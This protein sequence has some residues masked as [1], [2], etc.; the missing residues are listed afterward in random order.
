MVGMEKKSEVIT[1]KNAGGSNREVARQTGLDRGTVSKY[2]E[3]Y[4]RRK[5]E[6]VESGASVDER[7]VQEELLK[8]PSYTVNGRVKR[9]YTEQIEERLTE[10]LKAEKRK[11]TILGQGHKQSM[12]NKQIY[13]ILKAEGHEISQATINNELARLRAKAKQ[14]FIRQTYDYGD[15][16]EY[17]FGEVRLVIGGVLSV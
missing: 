16:V 5:R 7:W 9:K 17:D 15:R 10:L 8:A 1:L 13:G 6:L 14:V 4:R 2:W 11:D 3:E 12:T